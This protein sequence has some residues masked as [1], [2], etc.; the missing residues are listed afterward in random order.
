MPRSQFSDLTPRE[1]CDANGYGWCPSRDSPGD[2]AIDAARCEAYGLGCDERYLPVV[3]V[4]TTS[5]A[6]TTYA[7]TPSPTTSAAPTASYAPTS[8][9]TTSAAPTTAPTTA[10]TWCM[11]LGY[12]PVVDSPTPSPTATTVDYLPEPNEAFRVDESGIC[13]AMN[14]QLVTD[15]VDDANAPSKYTDPCACEDADI[16]EENVILFDATC[17]IAYP[18]AQW[19]ST[20]ENPGLNALLC[21]RCET[22]GIDCDV[23][24]D[25]EPRDFEPEAPE[26]PDPT[27]EDA[28]TPAPTVVDTQPPT[29]EPSRAAPTPE[30]TILG[31]A[32][33]TR[34]EETDSAARRAGVAFGLF[35]AFLAL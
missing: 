14:G 32:P 31:T 7:P 18:G 15:D 35:I 10:A 17:P 1:L 3:P 16:Y 12:F 28:A 5:F 4:P 27:L 34:D 25:C 9:P 21:A 23:A 11:A 30:P 13:C 29:F 8:L 26:V 22:Y 24:A 2:D 33:P 19:C 6:P 20:R